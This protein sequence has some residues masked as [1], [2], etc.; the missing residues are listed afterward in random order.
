[1]TTSSR[2]NIS[3]P[4]TS[5]TDGWR[6]TFDKWIHEPAIRTFALIA[7]GMILTMLVIV[8]GL[9]SGAFAAIISTLMPPLTARLIGGGL[10]STAGG[11]A[12]IAKRR[13]T[14]RQHA[15]A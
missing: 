11:A 10:L 9:A 13:R 2:R 8:A 1:M 4:D 15:A 14:R 3:N 7:L 5:G 6:N 12:V